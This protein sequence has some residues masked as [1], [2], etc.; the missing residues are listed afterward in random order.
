MAVQSEVATSIAKRLQAEL[1]G[2]EQKA[3]SDKPTDKLAAYDAYVPESTVIR[4]R[5]RRPEG[6][7]EGLAEAVRLDPTSA[8]TVL[9]NA[10][11]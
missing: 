9:A 4:G 11:Y 7:K 3:I 2:R 10:Y 5:A 8:E 1:S 6:L